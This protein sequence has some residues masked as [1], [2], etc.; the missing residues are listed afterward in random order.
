MKISASIYSDKKRPLK[1]VIQDLMDH[2]VD[3]LHV[4][5][6]DDL[7][8]FNDIKTIRELCSIP[9]D[10][11][12]ITAHPS[13]YY[14]LLEENPVEYVTFQYEDLEESL[15]IPDTVT[16]K[17]G[18][19]VITPTAVSIFDA[20]P[21]FDFILIMATIPGQ[22]GGKF[23]TINFTKIREFGN[24]Y[25]GKSIHVDGGVNAEVSFII[26][27]MGVTSAVS[28]SYLFNSA[29]IG[30]ALM[31]LTKREVESH[32]SVRDFMIPIAESPTVLKSAVN[33]KNVLRSID[34][35]KLGFCLVLDA[36]NKFNGLVSNADVRKALLNNL[37]D[38][39]AFPPTELIN[40]SPVTINENT[41][42][43]EMLQLI[44]TSTFPILYLPVLDDAGFAKGIVTFV[45]LIKGEL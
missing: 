13:K 7:N 30:N 2:Q 40:P 27:N 25:P 32:F 44:K 21:D 19:A 26:R 35:G 1:E 10:L 28:G 20:Y 16:G 12:I 6:N 9:I 42:V 29:S 36:D 33:L 34:Q 41:T 31:N 23:D 17:K 15:N 11:H 4:D 14:T 38:I 3:L 18:I 43:L 8:V 22:S 24:N 37:D 45:N 5:C 39:N